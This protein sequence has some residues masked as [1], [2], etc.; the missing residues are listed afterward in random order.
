[1]SP[2][3]TSPDQHQAADALPVLPDS[4]PSPA[5]S[6]L[7]SLRQYAYIG[8]AAAGL[9]AAGCAEHPSHEKMRAEGDQI[10][11]SLTMSGGTVL[12]NYLTVTSESTYWGVSRKDGTS[13]GTL[14]HG[15][16]GTLMFTATDGTKHVFADAAALDAH[17]VATQ[18][19]Q[20]E[21][22]SAH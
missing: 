2:L 21:E 14:T 15:E 8:L 3:S 17:L 22:K 12:P 11:A 13:A 20:T 4:M 5:P 18:P 10:S 16:N 19:M 7:Q 6:L 1:M 9:A